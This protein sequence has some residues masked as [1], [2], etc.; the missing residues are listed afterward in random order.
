MTNIKQTYFAIALALGFTTA[1]PAVAADYY[2]AQPASWDASGAPIILAQADGMS[3]SSSMGAGTRSRAMGTNTS[4]MNN[5]GDSSVNNTA[6]GSFNTRNNASAGI[7][8]DM[9]QSAYPSSVSRSTNTTRSRTVM[10][11]DGSVSSQQM[12]SNSC[13]NRN[14]NSDGYYSAGNERSYIREQYNPNTGY[15]R[16]ENRVSTYGDADERIGAEIDSGTYEM[17][18]GTTIYDYD[19]N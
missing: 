7:D 14:I 10:D 3:G 1:M 15:Y 2:D 5:T 12:N 17:G 8:T 18:S 9:S 6:D 11:D 4:G 13:S 16:T 19:T